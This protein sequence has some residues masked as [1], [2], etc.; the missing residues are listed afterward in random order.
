MVP[1]MLS[2]MQ[3]IGTMPTN[4]GLVL[5]L[6]VKENCNRFKEGREGWTG[7]PCTVAGSGEKLVLVLG[8]LNK[9]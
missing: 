1:E 6:C 2:R 7:H 4:N 8:E 3:L 5:Q 9:W